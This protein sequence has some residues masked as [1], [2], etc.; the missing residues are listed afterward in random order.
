MK[1]KLFAAAMLVTVT[2][3]FAQAMPVAHMGK[4]AQL[5]L[6][7]DG[8]GPGAHAGRDGYC[9]RDREDWRGDWERDRRPPPPRFFV[10]PR[11]YDRYERPR[12]CPRGYHL[13]RMS[14][15]CRP[16]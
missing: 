13:G 8:C 1:V 2:G 16:D 5:M 9:R 3:Q 6:V 7:R 14:G 15:V 10:P 4:D 12:P 11:D